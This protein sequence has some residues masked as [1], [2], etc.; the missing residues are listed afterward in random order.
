[1]HRTEN[2]PYHKHTIPCSDSALISGHSPVKWQ[3]LGD[4]MQLLNNISSLFN[5]RETQ[6]K[7]L[8]GSYL[9]E[10]VDARWTS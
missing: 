9:A 6:K 10:Q 3:L 4:K 5:L 2:Y 8:R 1:M 7:V